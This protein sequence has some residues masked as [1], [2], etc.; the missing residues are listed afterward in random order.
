MTCRMALLPP[1]TIDKGVVNYMY[2]Y[3]GKLAVNYNWT[4]SYCER[5]FSTW[6]YRESFNSLY[7]RNCAASLQHLCQ[8]LAITLA[9]RIFNSDEICWSYSDLYCTEASSHQTS[10]CTSIGSFLATTTFFFIQTRHIQIFINVWLINNQ[11]LP[12]FIKKLVYEV[13][14]YFT[15]VEEV[16]ISMLKNILRVQKTLQQAGI[17]VVSVFYTK[18]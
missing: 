4:E 12:S 9:R 6:D 2:K 3:K 15:G 14:N 18:L 8:K 1:V 11:N 7:F 16:F 13:A 17:T 5:D 10:L